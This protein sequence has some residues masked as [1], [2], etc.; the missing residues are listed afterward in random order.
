[1]RNRIATWALPCLF[2][3]IATASASAV[4][5]EQ[6]VLADNPI[7]YWQLNEAAGS[8][9]VV[10]TVAGRVATVIGNPVLGSPGPSSDFPGIG[11]TG[12]TA[13]AFDGSGD[14]LETSGVNNVPY[15]AGDYSVELW[16]QASFASTSINR[17]LFS[18]TNA[19][20]HGTLLEIQPVSG[21]GR[22]LRF[23][24]RAPTGSSGGQDVFFTLPGNGDPFWDTFH[25]LV[26][27]KDD[28]TGGMVLYLDG[29]AVGANTPS[30]NF[31]ATAMT[32]DIGRLVPGSNLRDFLGTIDEV[33]IYTQALSASQVA[34]HFAA[35]FVP[36]PAS[37]S[38]LLIGG[39]ALLRRRRA[40][41]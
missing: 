37:I 5:Y 41:V 34:A 20:G 9:S 29:I 1:M 10:D 38:L 15:G 19:G 32:I 3:L 24:H 35:A 33:A 25:H 14:A 40:T 11:S 31:G 17:D 28:I 26:G 22:R 4:T 6:A 23:L 2:T 18:A 27:V 36:E 8:T 21:T 16:F 12:N 7:A 30:G 13:V 39:A